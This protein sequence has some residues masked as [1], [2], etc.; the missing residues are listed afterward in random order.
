V[1]IALAYASCHR[2]SCG[3]RLFTRN[4]YNF[5]DRF[6]MI[7]AGIASLLMRVLLIDGEAIVVDE[8][9]LSVFELLC[10]R[11]HMPPCFALSI[12]SSLMATTTG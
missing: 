1:L 8:S 2:D 6:P 3:L 7:V 12:L 11:Y 4:G 10:Y 5:A 9:S